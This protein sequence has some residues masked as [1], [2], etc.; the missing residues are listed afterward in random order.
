[1]YPQ[2]KNL[3]NDQ[4][5]CGHDYRT[6]S[7]ELAPFISNVDVQTKGRKVLSQSQNIAKTNSK[8]IIYY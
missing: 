5:E 4:H 8:H 1:M 6:D 3:K 7:L 2:E